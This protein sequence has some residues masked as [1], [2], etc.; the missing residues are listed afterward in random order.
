MSTTLLPSNVERIFRGF[1]S[2]E[3]IMA[4]YKHSPVDV[5]MNVSSYEG[6]PVSI[7]EAISCG[8]PVVA[9]DVGGNSE[10][11]TSKNGILLNANPPAREIADALLHML[12]HP[13]MTV[14]MRKESRDL[15]SRL[16]SSEVTY[17]RFISNLQ[18]IRR[19]T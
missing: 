16:Y 13:D 6:Q 7:K 3:K 11:V 14:Q 18:S 4:H 17:P 9:T 1:V 5:F 2:L 10:I 12:D 19:R 15:W 8:I